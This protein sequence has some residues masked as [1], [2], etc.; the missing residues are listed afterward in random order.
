[1]I[2]DFVEFLDG[3]WAKRSVQFQPFRVDDMEYVQIYIDTFLRGPCQSKITDFFQHH[4]LKYYQAENKE[5]SNCLSFLFCVTNER[6]WP[7]IRLK[8]IWKSNVSKSNNDVLSGT[9]FTLSLCIL[10]IKR[11]PDRSSLLYF[12]LLPLRLDVYNHDDE[13]IQVFQ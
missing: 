2:T 11:E 13:G 10:N 7:M 3:Y 8:M 6:I 5:L 4:Q 1:M 9:L 12:E